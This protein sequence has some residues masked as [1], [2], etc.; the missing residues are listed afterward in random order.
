MIKKQKK[1]LSSLE[2]YIQQQYSQLPLLLVWYVKARA[3]IESNYR[4]LTSSPE[5]IQKWN[6]AWIEAQSPEIQKLFQEHFGEDVIDAIS[7]SE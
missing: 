4:R 3:W 7:H 5:D 6:A 1:D 2:R